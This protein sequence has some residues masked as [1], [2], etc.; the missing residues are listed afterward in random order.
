MK[1]SIRSKLIL[2]V[3]GLLLFT[4]GLVMFAVS[5]QVTNEIRADIER[6]FK[7]K[8]EL[9]SRIQQI[10]SR[11]LTQTAVLLAD[12]PGLRAA[13]STQD[14]PTINQKLR[15]ELRVLLDFDPVIPDSLIPESYYTDSDS[16][17]LL[18]VCDP[19]GLII[20]QLSTI[21]PSKFSI[22][23][24]PGLTEALSGEYITEPSL[25]K[26][27]DRYYSVISV[28]IFSGDI[29]IGS[30]TYGY[31]FR[32]IEARQLA[33]DIDSEVSFFIDGE[34]V[35]SSFTYLDEQQINT[36]TKS[37]LSSGVDVSKQNKP[38]TTSAEL[39]HEEWFIYLAP[40]SLYQSIDQP[41]AYYVLAS[42]FSTRISELRN[43]QFSILFFGLIGIG[44]SILVGVFLASYISK[45]I[46]LLVSGIHRME[47][48]NYNEPV[49]IIS[50]D[51]FGLLT[52]TFN[53]L[54]STLKERLEMLKFVSNATIEAIKKN[55]TDRDLGG[56]RKEVT[57]FFSD[58]RGFT[59]WS[60]KRP[61]EEVISMLNQTL[62]F[63][64][65]LIRKHG[66]DIDKFVGDEL[67]AVFEGEHKDRKSVQAAIEIQQKA[68]ALLK[69]AGYEIAIGIGI[70]TGSV[71]MGAMGS[72]NRLDY[73][74]IGN[75]VNLGA[76]LCSAA[77]AHEI[78][79]SENTAR[80]LERS[81][82]LKELEPISVKGIEHPVQIYAVRWTD[83]YTEQET[84]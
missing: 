12:V 33:K 81:T 36:F 70:N 65:E 74:V 44:F 84:L 66:G 71:V 16:A 22:A 53:Q 57:V 69:N 40:M 58:I 4:I 45:P 3:S 21:P 24:R 54:L 11:Q 8:A 76:R 50:K 49:R 28:P 23:Q 80:N 77:K 42:S 29:I 73:T 62:S 9:F 37:V 64:A 72:D 14:T 60:E 35:K 39:N 46:E 52:E 30:L 55:L 25:W 20:G 59:K 6:N 13:V 31:P 17:G 75:H 43:L 47:K 82:Q 5:Y 15:D 18:L 7:E 51:E 79:L 67:V 32:T 34:M 41:K 38:V 2:S 27:T 61:P 19:Q 26:V 48:G 78:I 63:Q 56:Q 68:Q 1:L 83:S 10:R